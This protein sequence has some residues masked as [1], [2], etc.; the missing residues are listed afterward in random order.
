M[1]NAGAS[2]VYYERWKETGDAQLLKDIEA[3]N[4]DDVRSTHQLRDWLLTLRPAGT[5]WANDAWIGR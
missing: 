3:Y 5:P 2:I 4:L 1:T